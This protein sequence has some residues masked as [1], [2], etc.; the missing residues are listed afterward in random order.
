M[1]Q[2][3]TFAFRYTNISAKCQIHKFTHGAK[4]AFFSRSKQSKANQHTHHQQQGLKQRM[5]FDYRRFYSAKEVGEREVQAIPVTAERERNISPRTVVSSLSDVPTI[6]TEEEKGL[7]ESLFSI[8]AFSDYDD[9][10]RNRVCSWKYVKCLFFSCFVTWLFL[11][12]F[13]S[14]TYSFRESL[15]NHS[16]LYE[17]V[18]SAASKPLRNFVHDI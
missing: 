8:I 5:S 17:A 11:S 13:Y 3:Y 1:R 4:T 10:R 7:T 14:L 18:T 15:Q 9:S 2:S 6:E 12:L 16:G